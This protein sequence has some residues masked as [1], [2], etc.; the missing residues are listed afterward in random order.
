MLTCAL[1]GGCVARPLRPAFR[2]PAP[3][4]AHPARHRRSSCL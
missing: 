3:H 1:S 4:S 2:R